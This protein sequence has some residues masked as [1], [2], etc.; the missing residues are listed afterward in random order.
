M[1][2]GEI[3]EQF[4]NT[5]AWKGQ[6]VCGGERVKIVVALPVAFPDKLPNFYL[7]DPRVVIPH[8]TSTRENHLCYANSQEVFPIPDRPIQIIKDALRLVEETIVAGLIGTN[9]SDFEQEFEAYWGDYDTQK[10]ISLITPGGKPRSVSRLALDKKC[11]GA[12]SIF[13]ES[14]EQCRQ[15]LANA[16]LGNDKAQYY[17]N[18]YLPLKAA[19]RPPFPTK[20]KEIYTLL[21]KVDP[22]ALKALCDFLTEHKDRLFN[23]VLFSIPVGTHYAFGGWIHSRPKGKR[24]NKA[25]CPGF[26]D[27]KVTGKIL[28]TKCFPN[29]PVIRAGITRADPIRLHARIGLERSAEVFEKSVLVVGCG[30]IGCRIANLLALGGVGKLILVDNDEY[31]IENMARHILPAPILGGSKAV[32]LAALLKCQS[33]HLVVE[34]YHDDLYKVMA[35]RPDLII[36]NDLVVAATGD[37]NLELRLNDLL[38]NGQEPRSAI[39]T[40]TEAR[41]IASHAILTVPGKGGCLR[42]AFKLEEKQGILFRY[43]VDTRLASEVLT[44]EE[45]C[46]ATFQPYSALV[47]DQAAIVAA[48]LALAY[49]HGDIGVSSRWHQLGDLKTARNHGLDIS[50]LYNDNVG[51]ELIKSG[52]PRHSSCPACKR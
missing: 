25:I 24:G 18:I 47:A 17:E 23:Y 39:Y 16:S 14:K 22:D 8:L 13:G 52:F 46:Q 5:A 45:G 38:T 41:G 34:S 48:R 40:W 21:S 6:I 30:S 31:H 42:C 10:W 32:N 33:P 36:K 27:N 35:A 7:V 4:I 49:L 44:R 3:P 37:K 9:K 15:W 43:A 28:L 2:E 51:D 29:E 19:F 12:N 26:R 20:S 11:D 1:L 50:D